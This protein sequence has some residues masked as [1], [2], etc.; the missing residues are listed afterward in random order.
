MNMLADV[1]KSLVICGVSPI[2][3]TGKLPLT[4]P[5]HMCQFSDLLVLASNAI[6]DLI[7]IS[8]FV[9]IAVFIWAGIMLLTS[10]GSKGKLDQAKKMFT[11]VLKGYIII[12]VAWVVVYT[13][14]N[15]L[16]G[17]DYTLLQAP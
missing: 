3:S 6:T 5:H 8:T 9:A 16:V 11:T 4:D 10:G 12:L 7:V 15:V 1:W 17:S 14:M 2:D 13:I